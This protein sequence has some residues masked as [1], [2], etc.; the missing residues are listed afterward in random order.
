MYVISN[1]QTK[2]SALAVD[3]FFA[4]S[5]YLVTI[6]LYNSK[7]IFQYT[8]KRALR[9]V[10]GF[11]VAV[12]LSVTLLAV[13]TSDTPLQSLF[14]KEAAQ[15]TINNL[16]LRTHYNIPG[17]LD[18]RAI[19]GSLWTIPYEAFLYVL[20]IPLWWMSGLKKRRTIVLAILSLVIIL[21]F[22]YREKLISQ[23][24]P[25]IWLNLGELSRLACIFLMGA[26]LATE[27]ELLLK[28]RMIAVVCATGLVAIGFV[29]N[30][31]HYIA[32]LCV[33]YLIIHL[34]LMY[35][36]TISRV[37]SRGDYSYG[38]YLW[39]FPIQQALVF[40]TDI[41]EPQYLTLVALP[42]AY[43]FGFMSWH[44]IEH[45]FLKLKTLGFSLTPRRQ[46]E[47]TD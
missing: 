23:S 16:F 10:P 18:G 14:S 45:P 12:L 13:L 24:L 15:Y 11:W 47:Q 26:L 25:V 5:G 42:I 22:F 1:G 17:I 35:N 3:S 8:F 31:Y 27:N 30:I 37:T 29:M 33:P 4:I 46:T 28:N 36:K 7:S 9:I 44:G 43:V 41:E 38:I 21:H 39:G 2:F 40:F 34:G 20:I 32:F 6:S 19:N